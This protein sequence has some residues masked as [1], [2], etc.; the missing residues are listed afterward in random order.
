MCSD[1]KD[2]VRF[3][4]GGIQ[5]INFFDKF[6]DD[7]RFIDIQEQL[8]M[9]WKTLKTDRKKQLIKKYK[10]LRFY[11]NGRRDPPLIFIREIQKITDKTFN[12]E[13]I[14]SETRVRFGHGGNAATAKLPTTLTA[15]LAY[16]VGAMRDGTL[17]RCGKYEISYSQKN[18][19]WLEIIQNLLI[20]V[21]KP[22]NQPVI[23]NDRVTLSNR[24]IFECLHK[25]FDIPIGKK[26][27]WGTPDIIK[28]SSLE[29]QRYYIR[30]F[31]DA[32]GL[33]WK[34][35]FCQANKEAISFVKDTLEKLGIKT[36]KLSV[37]KIKG[38]KP[39]YSFNTSTKSH[40]R[41]IRL[42]GSLNPSKQKLFLPT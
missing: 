27:L 28:K 32:D 20:K 13:K 30:G 33:S 18:V 4:R 36:G 11:I 37:R 15:E 14:F 7:A 34:L 5:S 35:G 6:P 22:S 40:I 8:A 39:F 10:N 16:L 29:L 38:R 3:S 12:F 26:D 21:F 19:E 1:Y 2:S 41:F 31:Y 42:I 17:S 25:I 23:R 24:P 9:I